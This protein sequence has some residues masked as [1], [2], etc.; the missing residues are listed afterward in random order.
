MVRVATKYRGALSLSGPGRTDVFDNELLRVA[1]V[2]RSRNREH[3]P[4]APVRVTGSQQRASHIEDCQTLKV[5]ILW[6][7]LR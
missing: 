7:P 6:T 2:Q 1:T 3:F 4:H 5:R